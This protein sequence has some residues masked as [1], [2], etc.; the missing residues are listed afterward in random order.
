MIFLILLTCS[1]AASVFQMINVESLLRPVPP[2]DLDE[3]VAY[4]EQ[5]PIV[6]SMEIEMPNFVFNYDAPITN[7]T[8]EEKPIAADRRVYFTKRTW[9]QTL[10]VA[11]Y[12]IG[13]LILLGI[14]AKMILNKGKG[15]SIKVVI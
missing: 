3:T 5:A 4:T 8:F 14:T 13:S 7:G 10:I 1:Q 9:T 2:E 11:C 15:K 12:L 6:N